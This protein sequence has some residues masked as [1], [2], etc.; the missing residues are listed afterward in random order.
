MN[1]MTPVQILDETGCL[2]HSANTLCKGM[3]PTILHPAMGK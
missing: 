1:M 2:T 3:H